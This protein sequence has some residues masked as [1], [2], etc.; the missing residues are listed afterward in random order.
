MSIKFS[1]KN[2][3]NSLPDN[4]DMNNSESTDSTDSKYLGII[5]TIVQEL[6][7]QR[8]ESQAL[9][10]EI[11]NLKGE[12][13]KIS[14]PRKRHNRRN[15][16][17][18]INRKGGKPSKRIGRSKRNNKLIV[19][20]Q[21]T[22]YC[23]RS[24]I[25]KDAV[26]KGYSIVKVQDLNIVSTVTEYRVENCYSPS[27]HKSYRADRPKNHQGEFGIGIR[28]L[29]LVLKFIANVSETRILFLLTFLGISIS[30]STISRLSHEDIG[31][32]HEEKK[33][34][35]K[36]GLS[37]TDYQQIDDTGL[38][39]NGNQHHTHILC[40]PYYTAYIT[41]PN[42]DRL[43]VLKL[44][45]LG[46]E[47]KFLFDE[48]AF[49]LLNIFKLPNKIKD[50]LIANCK[51]KIL[52]EKDL[53]EI[54]NKIPIS[55][56]K[57]D[58]IFRR[59]KEASGIAWYKIQDLV[60]VIQFLVSDDAPQ[61]HHLTSNQ[62]LC[63]IHEG[64]AIKKLC[65][66]T[67]ICKSEVD[68]ILTL[69]WNYY[70]DLLDFQMNPDPKL[71]PILETRFDEIFLMKTDYIALNLVLKRIFLKKENLLM[72]LRNP[73]LPL[74]N[75]ASEQGA[76]MV[77]RKRDVSLQARTEGGVIDLDTGLTIVQTAI[78]L[79]LNPFEYFISRLMEKEIETLDKIILRK[80]LNACQ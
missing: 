44:M 45:L 52:S 76:R 49:N 64:R 41:K 65:P 14:I 9:K 43:T 56:K 58:Q 1:L 37:S 62:S 22:C 26:S 33:D 13:G 19:T 11:N 61:F 80:S 46:E 30:Q 15:I 54:L 3:L 38:N 5:D 23:D 31:F 53:D 51:G 34:I 77:V 55:N 25:P 69:F 10:D 35:L 32:F 60:P 21:V 71:V 63:W 39:V 18:E 57:P 59:I 66:I 24:K 70:R 17:S 29:I 28:C 67:S 48:C 2:I 36:A 50:Y 42:K 8:E 78:K 79:G 4:I 72:V 47:L 40:N 27:E 7:E 20:D 68:K 16:S 12:Q 6:A 74:H 73:K 75:N